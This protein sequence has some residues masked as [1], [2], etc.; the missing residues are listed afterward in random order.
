MSNKFSNIKERILYISEL[1]NITREKFFKDLGMTY[2]NFTGKAK[3]TPVNSNAIENILL[4]Y[5]DINPEWLLTGKGEILK[6]NLQKTMKQASE[7]ISSNELKKVEIKE[8]SN[9]KWNDL[10]QLCAEKANELSS[11]NEAILKVLNMSKVGDEIKISRKEVDVLNSF[12]EI[13]NEKIISMAFEGLLNK[14]HESFDYHSFL[15]ELNININIANKMLLNYIDEVQFAV[16][17]DTD[18]RPYL[19]YPE[20]F[21]DPEKE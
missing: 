10:F 17:C 15:N 5:D 12:N 19:I 9:L 13:G 21:Y 8:I 14:N 2:G 18:K 20:N 11:I 3:E 7:P 4:K 16:F 1:K 6:T